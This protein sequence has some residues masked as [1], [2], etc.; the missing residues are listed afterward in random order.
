[1]SC[2]VCGLAE[3]KQLKQRWELN[4]LSLKPIR[5]PW[6]LNNIVWTQDLPVSRTG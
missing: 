1:M 2:Y 3:L 5:N 6:E 4:C